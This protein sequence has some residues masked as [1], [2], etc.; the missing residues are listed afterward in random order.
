MHDHALSCGGDDSV[1][2]G[3]I[4]AGRETAEDVRFYQ[5][6][7]LRPVCRCA[8][9]TVDMSPPPSSLQPD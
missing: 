1:Y 8:P 7:T 9:F 2:G 3:M 6:Q 5:K 4:H